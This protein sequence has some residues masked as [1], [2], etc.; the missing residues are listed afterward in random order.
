MLTFRAEPDTRIVML[1]VKYLTQLISNTLHLT[2]VN[3]SV[4]GFLPR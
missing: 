3:T 2:L 1:N 4:E